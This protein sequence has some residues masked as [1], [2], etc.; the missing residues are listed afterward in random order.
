MKKNLFGWLA[1]A[2]MLV[3]TGC[4]TDEVV[5]DYSPENAIQFGTYVGRDAQGRASLTT[6]ENI[7]SF[8]VFAIY[9]DDD[10]TT[11]VTSPNFMNNEVVSKSASTSDSPQA[12]GTGWTYSPI[13]YWPNEAGDLIDFYAYSPYESNKRWNEGK[14]N[15]SI[16]SDENNQIDY[17]V[18]NAMLN[19]NKNNTNGQVTFTFNHALSRVGFK[20]EAVIDDVNSQENGDLN[21]TD[22]QDEVKDNNTIISVQEVQ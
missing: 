17:L 5:N 13:K 15:I 4:S 21:D 3:G 20:V 8:G 14:V 7:R 1:M 12:Y 2:A 11:A 9:H 16:A 19:K 10:A 6:T 18:A 22:S